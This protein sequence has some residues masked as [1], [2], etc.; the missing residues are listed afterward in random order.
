MSNETIPHSDKRK[1]DKSVEPIPQ[2]ITEQ[3]IL[4]AVDKATPN[5]KTVLSERNIPFKEISIFSIKERD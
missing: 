5:V 1:H 3:Y 2:I 4:I